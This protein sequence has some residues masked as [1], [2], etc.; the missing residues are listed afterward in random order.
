M[1]DDDLALLQ[2]DRLRDL[3]VDTTISLAER[4][5]WDDFGL[6]KVANGVA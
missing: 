2:V 3:I 4:E 5:G 6:R 1:L